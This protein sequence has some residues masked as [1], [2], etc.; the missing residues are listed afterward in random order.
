[1][2]TPEEYLKARY[3]LQLVKLIGLFLAIALLTTRIMP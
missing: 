2:T 1:M 3:Q